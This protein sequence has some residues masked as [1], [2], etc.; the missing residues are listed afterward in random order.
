MSAIVITGI[1]GLPE[2][3]PGD[4]VVTLILDATSK[5]GFTFVDGDILVV[6]SKI[7]SKTE[8]RLIRLDEV[9]PSQIALRYSKLLHMDPRKA[10]VVLSEAQRTVRMSKGLI[11]AETR[12]GFIC[13]NGGI[14]QSNTAPGVI[15]LL[16]KNPDQS[17]RRI[18]QNI[19]KKIGV[20]VAVVITDTFGRPWREGQTNV[21]IGV[22]GLNPLKPYSGMKDSFG[23]ELK[24]TNVAVADEIASASEL[25]MGKLDKVPV[26][27][28]RGY[29]YEPANGS[30]RNL[31]RKASKDLFR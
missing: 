9:E 24:V 26:A 31:V 18:A 3:N 19:K 29:S 10:E 25:V 15:A 27:V 28:V 14:D 16:P 21:A 1:Q 20:T 4:D 13:A 12:Q 6:T 8:G 7:V 5:Q 17:A 22:A 11:I 30:S 2:I 23:Y